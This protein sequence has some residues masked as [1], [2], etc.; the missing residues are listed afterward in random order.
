MFAD[1]LEEKVLVEDYRDHDNHHKPHSALDFRTPAEVVAAADLG[2][3]KNSEKPEELE[4]VLTLSWHL[5]QKTGSDHQD[6]LT[7][8]LPDIH[9]RGLP[10][11]G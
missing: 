7:F 11:G 1:L 6:V 10:Q 2:G 3:K 4:P 9:K 8:I 5:V